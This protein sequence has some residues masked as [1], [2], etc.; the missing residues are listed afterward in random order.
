MFPLRSAMAANSGGLLL[1]GV[2]CDGVT[3]PWG[4]VLRR[5]GWKGRPV[6]VLG[7]RDAIPIGMQPMVSMVAKPVKHRRLAMSLLKATAL[8]KSMAEHVPLHPRP[9][10]VSVAGAAHNVLTAH[11]PAKS[12]RSVGGRIHGGLSRGAR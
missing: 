2:V 5:G 8:M 1:R 3:W 6:I 10:R 4:W 7:K 11:N 12:L 9:Q